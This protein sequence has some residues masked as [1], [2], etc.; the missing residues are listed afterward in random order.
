MRE[1][2]VNMQKKLSEECSGLQ[3]AASQLKCQLECCQKKL[4]AK[5]RELQ[6][7]QCQM[8][9]YCNTLAVIVICDIS[10][11]FCCHFNEYDGNTVQFNLCEKY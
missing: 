10:A 9:E 3:T 1:V 2:Y 11:L 4:D 6:E 5:E 7:L 8:V